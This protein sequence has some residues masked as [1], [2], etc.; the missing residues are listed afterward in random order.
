MSEPLDLEPILKRRVSRYRAVEDRLALLDEVQRLRDEITDRANVEADLR[1]QLAEA[2]SVQRPTIEELIER[3]SLGSP[4]AKAA[5]ASADP[6]QVQ[7]ILRRARE[8]ES[9]HREQMVD[10]VARMLNGDDRADRAV[11][12]PLARKIVAAI[13]GGA[14]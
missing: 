5:R 9:E 8:L 13:L 11:A 2:Q 7:K 12:W 6:E 14:A 1:A 4:E 10:T 3:S